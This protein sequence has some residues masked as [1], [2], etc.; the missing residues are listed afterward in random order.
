MQFILL[1]HRL[2]ANRRV[3]MGKAFK[4]IWAY[5]EAVRLLTPT[6]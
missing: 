3:A 2:Q 5:G 1:C 4:C 6:Q